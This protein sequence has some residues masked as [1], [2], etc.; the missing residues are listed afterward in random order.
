MT[1]QLAA[2]TNSI[3]IIVVVITLFFAYINDRSKPVTKYL[4]RLGAIVAGWQLCAVMYFLVKNEA[5]ALWTYTAKLVFAALAPIQLLLLCVKFYNAAS[6]HKTTILLRCLYIIPTVTAIL[7]LTAPYHNLLRAELYF[8]QFEPIH[9]LHNVRGPW[10]WI[11]TIYSYILMAAAVIFI[12]YQHIKLP[13]GFRMPSVLVATGSGI[14]LLCS[15]STVF[16]SLSRNIDLTLVGLSIAV[17][18]TY[19]GITVSDGSSLLVHAFDNIF[20]YLEDYIFILNAK[21]NVIAMNPSARRWIL[22]LGFSEEIVSFEQII[23]ELDSLSDSTAN[24]IS[25]DEWDYQLT[26]GQQLSHYNLNKR[27]IIDQM[28]KTIGTFAIFTDITRY[29][30]LIERIE[31]SADVD[32]LTGFG[33]RRSYEQALESLDEP[34]SLPF[35][36]I[37]GDVNYLKYVNDN[38]GH[39]AGDNL[40]CIIADNLK[41][42]SP[43][44]T[45]IFR[46]GGDEFVVLLPCMTTDDA[47]VIVADIREAMVQSSEQSAFDV[48]IALGIATKD[49]MEQSIHE[50]IALADRNMYLNKQNDRRIKREQSISQ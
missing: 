40:L 18:F 12:L 16:T 21:N 7:A 50:C 22:T 14:V 33:N 26:I 27:P 17:A 43:N 42:A 11:H 49:A 3:L 5:F 6:S 29:K 28:D 37:L 36:V 48:S 38:M 46:I 44:G 19:A 1:N 31:R 23:K 24:A 30:L 45:R 39:T 10:F 32:P 25:A 41:S 20:A 35:S 2:I 15:F 9:V 4:M 8:E 13:K 34:E 47:E